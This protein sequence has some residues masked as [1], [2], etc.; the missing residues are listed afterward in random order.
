MIKTHLK[1]AMDGATFS[2]SEAQSIM[3]QIMSGSVTSCQIASLLTILKMR[4][5]TVEELT[6]FAKSMRKHALSFPVNL[7]DTVDTCGTGGDGSGT[8]NISTASALVMASLGVKVA[9]HGNRSFSSKSGSAD[10]LER[11]NVP[12]QSGVEDAMEAL[13]EHSMSFLFAPLYHP[14]MKH[15]VGPRKEIGFRTVFNILGPLCNPARCPRQLIGVYDSQLA[16]KMAEVVQRL[17]IKKAMIVSGDDGLDECTITTTTTILEV[18]PNRIKT[19]TIHPEDFGLSTGQLEDIQVDSPEASA[20]LIKNVFN[21]SA[22]LSA[23]NIV[24]LNTAA[25]L[26]AADRADDFK[27]AVPIVKEAIES[28]L[29]ERHY[30]NMAHVQERFYA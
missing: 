1:N 25:G 17:G 6:G 4:G 14:A 30:H 15:A 23:K 8:F 2:E 28:G 5:E 29:V 21:N 13:R 7:H 24:I 27:T 22:N 20:N 16:I 18:T 26:V 11:L 3:D 12:T 10:V 19:Y 9:K